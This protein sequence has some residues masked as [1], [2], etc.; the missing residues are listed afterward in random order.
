M[1][2]HKNFKRFF[3]I[4]FVFLFS[5]RPLFCPHGEPEKDKEEGPPKIGNFSLD[6]SQQI[7]P[8]VSFGQNIVDKNQ[9][10]LFLF[11]DYYKGSKK[12]FGDIFP[13][14]LF[15]ITD[16]F[17]IFLSTPV[18]VSYRENG[19]R[20]SGLEDI[21]V[22]AEYAFYD[23]E[24]IR[25]ADLA[26]LV[27]NISFPT[28]STKK[29]P[30]TGFGSPSFFL[31]GTFSRLYTDWYGFVSAGTTLTTSHKGTKFGNEFFYQGGFGRNILGIT[32]K[33]IFSW[34]V[35]I[36]G[37]YVQRSKRKGIADPDSGGNLVFVTPSL[38]FSTQKF[39]GQFGI[40]FPVAQHLFG[41]QKKN[42][43]LLVGELAWLFK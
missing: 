13:F 20:S 25:F 22:Q 31:G 9:L 40:G 15:G 17:S 38:W 6:S 3:L 33:L 42:N 5:T 19:S 11:S 41:N 10:Q 7:G 32:S 34:M 26:T 24:T 14:L 43:Y 12:H 39:I 29:D 1:L 27:A 18:A 36:N 23:K 16:S 35:E 4:F 28:G 2:Y 21:F 37:F 30:A 8:L